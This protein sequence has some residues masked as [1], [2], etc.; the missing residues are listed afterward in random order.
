MPSW[1]RAIRKLQDHLHSME[2]D[3][4]QMQIAA[5]KAERDAL[6][7]EN[8]KLREGLRK[9]EWIHSDASKAEI[10]SHCPVC[11]AWHGEKHSR[12]CWLAALLKVE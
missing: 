11:A 3:R 1:N 7:D 12:D 5:L 8:A 2:V 6:R 10:F 4:F 9:L